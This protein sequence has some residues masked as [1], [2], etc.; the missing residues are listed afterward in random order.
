V[1]GTLLEKLGTLLPK[2][3]LIAT[4]FPMLLFVSA[5]AAMLYATSGRFR[6]WTRGALALDTGKQ[7][8]LGFGLL[9]GLTV[10]AYLFSTLNLFLRQLLEGEYLG[11]ALRS[12]LIAGQ[13]RR[14]DAMEKVRKEDRRRRRELRGAVAWI[15]KLKDARTEGNGKTAQC[16]YPENSPVSKK[17][18]DLS[19]K[20]AQHGLI[21]VSELKTAVDLLIVE[22]GKSPVDQRDPAALDF[23]DKIR[24]AADHDALYA[25]I[26]YAL[27][28]AEN[29]YSAS[30]NDVEFNY[31]G[32]K[33]AP[34]AMGN[35]AESVRGYARSRY[36]LNLDPFWL[37]MQKTIQADEQFYTLLLDAK[38]QLDFLIS[39]FW[40]TGL[41][42]VIWTFILVAWR[43]SLG[44]F[45]IVGTAGPGLLVLWYRIA[46]QNYRAFA[47]L[48]R[49]SLDLYRLKLLSALH[50][51]LPY[52]TTQERQIWTDLNQII[53]FGDDMTT[54]SYKHP[55]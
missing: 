55:K 53:G 44:L 24:L 18:A 45:L 52:G 27:S 48:L 34:T 39:L 47:D 54:I 7:A 23:E 20:K 42:T 28:Y 15:P 2:N 37:R 49:A 19:G 8:L 5:N 12:G 38:T 14:L 13:Q 16:S 29:E 4:F 17:V 33:L 11:R 6:Q 9:L 1:L 50:I 36:S 31:S 51:K 46:L 25:I 26:H 21:E 10:S 3:F 30:F 41:F 43:G 40:L 22:L 32:Y 35:I